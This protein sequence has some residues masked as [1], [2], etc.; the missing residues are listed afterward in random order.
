MQYFP[1]TGLLWLRYYELTAFSFIWWPSAILYFKTFNIL[2]AG[3]VWRANMR[4]QAKFRADRSN[5][6]GDLALFR[7]FKMAVVRHLGFVDVHLNYPRRVFVGLC[8]CAKCFWNR[9]RSLDN[10]LCQF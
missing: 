7:F 3:H 6:C 4:H 10:L 1:A 9:C 5:R 2:T 8:H